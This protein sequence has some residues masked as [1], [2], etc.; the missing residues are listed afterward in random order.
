[1]SKIQ[2]G[3]IM[4]SDSDLRVVSEAAKVLEEF[5]IGFEIK[6]YSAHR[7]PNKA[8]EYAK[9]AVERGLKVIIAAAS[10]AAHL[11]GV[12]AAHT[13]LPVIGLPVKGKSLEGLDSLL[14]IVQMPPGVPVATVSVDGARN[15]GILAVQILA[16]S[17]GSLQEKVVKFKQDLEESGV[18]K[19]AK[20]DQIGY[21]AYLE[22]MGKEK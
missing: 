9:T 20:I 7:A 8:S 16:L 15:A 22:E 1:M 3:I 17:E 14:S 18:K 21:L 2:V 6:F 4:G 10:G 5:G 11:P 19:T 13:P 12:I